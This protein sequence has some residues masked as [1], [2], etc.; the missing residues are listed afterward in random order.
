MVPQRG[1]P[2]PAH[3][4]ERLRIAQLGKEPHNKIRFTTDQDAVIRRMYEVEKRTIKEVA[5][6]IGCSACAIRRRMKELGIAPRTKTEFCV[7]RDQNPKMRQLRR[8]MGAKGLSNRK[9]KNLET[10][11]TEERRKRSEAQHQA[12]LKR[13]GL[14]KWCKQGWHWS[15]KIQREV[16]YRSGYERQYMEQLDADE[17]VAWY[18]YEPRSVRITYEFE[19]AKKIYK[20]DFLVQYVDGTKR[21]VE[22]KST[23]TI[24]FERSRAKLEALRS[25]SRCHQLPMPIDIIIGTGHKMIVKD[26]ITIS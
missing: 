11:S 4:V 15:P 13:P 16:F 3:V 9:Y 6:E 12:L 22:L 25:L 18:E 17:S 8:I 20:P 24:T 26:T 23:W 1:R 2:K 19:G 14:H 21:L 10:M 7:L 5:N